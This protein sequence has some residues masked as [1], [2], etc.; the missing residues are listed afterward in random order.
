MSFRNVVT[1]IVSYNGIKWIDNCL[2]S[3]INSNVKTD[4]IAVDNG[5][6]DGTLAYL[7][8]CK[9]LTYLHASEENLGFGKANNIGL[10][11][12]HRKKYKYIFLLNQDAWVESNTL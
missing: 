5:S 10:E 8:Q 3:L 9:W 4:V 2:S 12:A 11:I 6:T 1:I 7:K